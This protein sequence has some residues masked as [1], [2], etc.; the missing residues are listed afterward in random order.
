M[1]ESPYRQ[2]ELNP[3]TA[4][5]E[6]HSP[7]QVRLQMEH[8]RKQAE[9]YEAQRQALEQSSEQ[10]VLF[11]ESLN[12]LGMRLH[13]AVQRLERELKSM[14]AEQ[15]EV[16]LAYQCLARH[17]QI[18]SALQPKTWS[19]EGFSARLSDALLKLER[20][21]NDFNEVFRG[22]HKYLHTDVFRFKPGVEE[23]PGFGWKVL[24]EQFLKGLA[25]H[26]PLFCLLLVTWLIY[27]LATL[28]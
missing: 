21:E 20:A 15:E 6:M 5:G 14:K 17:L 23:K 19:T 2:M 12:D 9:F 24:K 4:D 25:F 26:L 28:A 22:G 7:E 18:L 16:E 11:D 27:L 10:K 1:P 8:A 3:R 13:N